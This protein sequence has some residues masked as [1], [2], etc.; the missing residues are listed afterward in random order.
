MSIK[1]KIEQ[2]FIEAYKN[3]E[4]LKVSV[5]RLVKSAVKNAEIQK[6]EELTDDDVITVMKKEAKQ[7]RETIKEFEKAN[8]LEAAKKEEMELNIIEA[9]LPKQ[10]SEDEVKNIVQST[11]NELDI[12]NQA[13]I[14][15][16]IGAVMSKCGNLVD[17]NTV[18][19]IARE[20]L[21][22]KN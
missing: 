4:E 11:I 17:G 22:N 19:R 3:R 14:G 7:R 1:A 5:L 9:Y 8:Q 6:K 18:S 16:L 2:D 13:Q 20:T 15:K 21:Q 12:E 10:L